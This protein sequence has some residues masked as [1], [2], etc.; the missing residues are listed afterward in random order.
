[1]SL[2]VR[3]ADTM[4]RVGETT[5]LGA[6]AVWALPRRPLETRAFLR[7]AYAQGNRALSLLWI[8]AGF[9][10][11][12]MAFQFG[13]SLIR[14]GA[15]QY[16]GQLTGLALLRELMPVLTA[17]V[18]GGRIAAG[19]AAELAAMVA[20]EQIAAV[21]ALGA[22]PV[23]KLVAPRIAAT[24]LVLPLMVVL[25]DVIG[26]LAGALVAWLEFDVP[27]RFYLVSARDFLR[28]VDFASGVIKAA[29]FG[30]V[31]ATIACR[32]GLRAAPT[33]A[34]VGRATTSA[35]VH[36]SL[37]VVVLDYVITRMFFAKVGIGR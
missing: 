33:T 7:E 18:L 29:V 13:Q 20:T 25:G 21:R 36:A 35:V 32:E 23:K 3:I 4:A 17:L 27:P 12:V 24:T 15:R 8:M 10:G 5:L 34:G 2:G 19:T 28:I 16:V 11:L 26:M 31:G 9:A 30:F 14:F 22:D 1:V 6:R 37:A